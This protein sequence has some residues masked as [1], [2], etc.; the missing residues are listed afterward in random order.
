MPMGTKSSTAIFQRV[1]D[2]VLAPFSNTNWFKVRRVDT[3][4]S[5]GS[6]EV[7]PA[8]MGS[9]RGAP[10]PEHRVGPVGWAFGTAFAYV[11][12]VLICSMGTRDGMSST[13]PRLVKDIVCN[14]LPDANCPASRAEGRPPRLPCLT[15][16]SR[17]PS[18]P[19]GR[20]I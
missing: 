9:V 14:T 4:G 19:E 18:H 2:Q 3:T 5:D 10:A 15:R 6:V 1:M 7:T 13:S 12:D 8:A 20:N 11:D 17:V 16:R